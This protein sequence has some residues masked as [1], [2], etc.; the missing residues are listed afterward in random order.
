MVKDIINW[1]GDALIIQKQKKPRLPMHNFTL[2]ELRPKEQTLNFIR[3]FAY[4]YY[5][6]TL[7]GR[8]TGCCLN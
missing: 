7:A 3:Q 6:L 5:T 8:E 1:G 4:T 2:E